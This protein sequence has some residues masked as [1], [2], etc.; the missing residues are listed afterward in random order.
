MALILRK[1]VKSIILYPFGGIT[2]IDS[3]IN[4]NIRNDFL[5]NISGPLFQVILI[6]L[7]FCLKDYISNSTY[8]KFIQ[9]NYLLLSFNMLPILP[10]DG[11][12]LLNIITDLIFPYKRSFTICL[13]I[14]FL[15]CFS[16]MIFFLLKKDILISLLFLI[17]L[18]NIIKEFK[19]LNIKYNK[20]LLERVLYDYKFSKIKLVKNHLEMKRKYGYKFIK[21]N[22]IYNE[23]DYLKKYVFKT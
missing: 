21:N 9:I 4:A 19:Y 8:S 6:I 11:G 7:I 1:E 10:L 18:N 13:I 2:Y 22:L 16:F 15:V 14:S 3:K 12:R 20:F 23:K 5:I 17:T